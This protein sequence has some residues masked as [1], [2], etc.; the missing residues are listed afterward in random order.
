MRFA[1]LFLLSGFL[2]PLKSLAQQD[3][4]TVTVAE[5]TNMAVALSPDRQKLV[6][7]LQGTLWVMPATG[8][9][10]VA[11]TDA[12]GDCR[13]PAWSP[14]GTRIAFHAFWDGTYHLWTINPDGTGLQ[15]LTF[16]IFDDREPHWSPD[17]NSLVFASDRNGNYDIW[18]L[19]LASGKLTAL[20]QDPANDYGSSYSPDGQK[21]AYISARTDKGGLYVLDG[22]KPPALV[23]PLQATL[24]APA[25]SPDNRRVTFQA[26]EK[27]ASVLYLADTQK[28]TAEVISDPNEDVF[29][30]RTQFVSGREFFYTA[31][32][33]IKRRILGRK[34]GKPL[35]WQAVFKLH[36]PK[37]K[38]K[39]YDFDNATPRAVK[40]VKG[41]VVSPDGRQVAFVALGNLWT[42]TIGA[43]TATPLTRDA[44]IENDPAWSPDGQRLAYV[45]DRSGKMDLWIRNL[46]TGT[47]KKV[48]ESTAGILLPAWS[49]DGN[50]IAF[51]EADARNTWGLATLQVVPVNCGGEVPCGETKKIHAPLF[52]PGQASWSPDGRKMVVSALET[53]STKYREGVSE[54]LVISLDGQP[55]QFISPHPERTLSQRGKNGPLWSPDGKWM[56]YVLDGLLWIVP[57]SPEG[58]LMGPPKRLTNELAD[59]LSWTADSKWLAYW[60]VDVLKKTNIETGHTQTIPLPVTWQPQLPKDRVVIHAGRL[61]D[62]K[63]NQYQTNV[64]VVIEGHRIKEIVPHQANRTEKTIDASG[65]TLMPGLFEMHTHQSGLVG[66]KL[67]RLWLSYGIT[68]I[69]EP[70][71]DPYDAIERREAWASGARLGPRQFLTGG[72]TDGTRIYYGQATSIYSTSHLDL[73]LNRAVRLEFDFMKTYVRLSD[74]YQRRIT[75]FAH[76]NGI[77]VSSHEIY[78]ATQ[79]NVDAVEHIGATS[80]RGYSPKITSTNHAYNDVIQLI[81]KSGMNI[82]PT[83]SL[84]GGFFSKLTQDSTLL[85][86]RQFAAFY[87]PSLIN[88]LKMSMKQLLSLNPGLLANFKNLQDNLKR[89]HQAGASITTGTDSPFVPYGTSLHVEMQNLADAGIAP[90]EVLRAATAR[91]A[92][93]VGVGKDLGTVEPG[94]LADLIIVDGDPLHNVRDARNVVWVVKNGAVH[95]LDEL[96]KRP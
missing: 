86:H 77:P 29:P 67:G 69:R 16:G 7:D 9:K 5:G 40:G 52:T 56:A 33:Q 87:P 47:E 14:D 26:A 10:A 11:I 28:N 49:P 95:S 64:D 18:K 54:F 78:P 39:T 60:S 13:Q 23:F 45:S 30:F 57:V 12:L 44:Y 61:F 34:P 15:Q 42:H 8:G 72:L 25:W 90:F 75:E 31:D 96:L 2:L 43:K 35:V 76:Q 94:K 85:N 74:T 3:T 81:A 62:G 48:A 84:Q 66:E 20:T 27:G 63:T 41:P 4:V 19:E 24:A 21:I 58:I 6:M 79:Y 92:E 46:I 36:R 80:R 50:S 68:S 55:D 73:E 70:G 71:A 83:L 38:R 59:N 37:Y 32:G 1:S 88:S 93:V 53:Y 91:A 65:K 89:L 22:E 17:G 51:F 82:T